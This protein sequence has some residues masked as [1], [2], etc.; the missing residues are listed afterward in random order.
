MT[1]QKNTIRHDG[2]N[3]IRREKYSIYSGVLQIRKSDGWIIKPRSHRLG[4]TI[5]FCFQTIKNPIGII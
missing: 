3:T 2:K 4:Q 1:R 5:K